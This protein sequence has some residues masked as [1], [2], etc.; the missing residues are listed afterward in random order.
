MIY[1]K[2]NERDKVKKLIK[3]NYKFLI[4]IILMI[5]FFN[6]RLPYYIMSPGGTINITDRVEMD[7]YKKN[8]GSI[9]ML[10][11]SEYEMTPAMGLYS[12]IR[13]YDINKNENRKISNESIEEV[14][15]RNKI[16]RDNSLDIALMVAYQKAGKQI[17]IK[18]KKN[19]VIATT[20]DNE[21]KVGDIILKVD[22]QEVNDISEIK[23]IINEKKVDDYVTFSILR[24]NKEK[25]IKSKIYE[26]N[27]KL[28]VGI[29]V[30]TDFE[31]NIEPKINLKFKD[32]ESGSSGGLMLTLTIYNALVEEDILKGRKIAG[33]GTIAYDGSVGE[34]DGV[35]YKIMGAASNNV[36]LVFVPNANYKEAIKTKNKYHYNMEIVGVDTFEEALE[37]L[38]K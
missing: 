37:Y 1:R 35:K 25:E 31:Y 5:L 4:T 24:N 2:R 17:D 15:T 36:S 33:T 38:L 6:I 11:V 10:Y 16:M 23:K 22:N 7:N 32:R 3:E 14:T 18:N 19:V 21:F 29:V 20:N 30:I 27:N 12:L 28:V 13:G 8:N 9:N 26:E 34:I